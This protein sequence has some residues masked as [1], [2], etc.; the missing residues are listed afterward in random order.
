MRLFTG[1]FVPSSLHERLA[2]LQ[3]GVPGAR[4][5]ARENFHITLS[6][7][8]D[9]DS[10]SVDDLIGLLALVEGAPFSLELKGTGSFGSK[11]PRALWA[12]LSPSEDLMRLQEKVAGLLTRSGFLDETRQ[13]RPHV[14]LAY[15]KE[16]RSHSE[17]VARYLEETAGFAAPPFEVRGFDLI[18]SEL[19][20]AG[21]RYQSLAHFPLI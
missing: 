1:L 14:T 18:E 6:F 15:L 4:W 20:P 13:Y 9:V 16:T 19:T 11:S 3:G 21:P 7:L 5:V 2:L 8:G 10:R 12:G 17:A